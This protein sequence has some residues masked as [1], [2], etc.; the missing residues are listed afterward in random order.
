[1][2]ND[3]VD[4]YL[5]DISIETAEVFNNNTLFTVKPADFLQCLFTMTFAV[6]EEKSL[7]RQTM[8]CF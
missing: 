1:M 2:A 8:V 3:R 6:F 5:I 7:E 4:T